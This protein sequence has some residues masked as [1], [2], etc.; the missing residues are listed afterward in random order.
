M[1]AYEVEY[2][3]LL[4]RLKAVTSK[5]ETLLLSIDFTQ[6]EKKLKTCVEQKNTEIEVLKHEKNEQAKEITNFKKEITDLKDEIADLKD[7]NQQIT[8]SVIEGLAEM[9]EE[10]YESSEVAAD[11]SLVW[12]ADEKQI[13][14]ILTYIGENVFLDDTKPEPKFR[15]AYGG[16]GGMKLTE[17]NFKHAITT[18]VINFLER[19]LKTDFLKPGSIFKTPMKDSNVW[20]TT[21]IKIAEDYLKSDELKSALNLL[22]DE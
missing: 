11:G 13:N 17:N 18:I 12:K 10:I 22:D 4:T 19:K 8:E 14:E 2:K 20:S 6:L 21:Y 16:P 15:Y 5:I 7:E 1:S 3:E 9:P